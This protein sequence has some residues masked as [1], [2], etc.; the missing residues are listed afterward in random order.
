MAEVANLVE[1]PAAVVG[2][3]DESFLQLP[4]GVPDHADAGAPALLPAGRQGG[5]AAAAVR[6]RGQRSAGGHG[7][8]PPRQRKA[9]W[10]PGSRTRVLLRRRPEDAPGR[11]RPP[12]EGRGVPGAAGHGARKGGAGAGPGGVP[13]AWPAR[14]KRSWPWSTGP[15]TWPKPTWSP[16]WCTNSPSCRASWAGNTRCCRGE[17]EAVADAVFEHYLPRFAGDELPRTLAGSILSVAD[18]LDTI[19]GC[20]G[21]D[22]IPTG[23]QDPYTLPAPGAGRRAHRQR[24][25]AGDSPRGSPLGGSGRLRRA[26]RRRSRRAAAAGDGLLRQRVR[27]MLLDQGVRHDLVEAVVGAGHRRF[28]RRVRQSRRPGPLQ[29]HRRVRGAGDGLRAGGQPGGQGGCR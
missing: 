18:K 24:F 2:S 26:V 14:T 29:R 16:R 27:G 11:R 19:V 12:A 21:V 20:F 10:R 17:G 4:R 7:R 15:P 23:Y 28:G 8:R 9:C 3:F 6:G 25:P 5:T 1:W 22:L 13:A